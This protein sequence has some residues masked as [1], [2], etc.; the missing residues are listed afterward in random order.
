MH[1]YTRKERSN[2]SALIVDDVHVSEVIENVTS[3]SDLTVMF[4]RTI[5]MFLMNSFLEN[6]LRL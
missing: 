2:R 1:R 3:S 6:F 4:C 5:V